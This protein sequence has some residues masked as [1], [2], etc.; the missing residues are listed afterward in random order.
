VASSLE[1]ASRNIISGSVKMVYAIVYSL[2]LGFSL[3]IGSDLYYLVDRSAR[4][5][6]VATLANMTDSYDLPGVFTDDNG[7]TIF[8]GAFTFLKPSASVMNTVRYMAKG[9]ARQVDGPWYLRQLPIW[10]LFILVPVYS[11]I[12]S[13]WKLQPFRSKQLVVMVVI[14]C[15]SYAANKGECSSVE[16][17]APF[18]YCISCQQVYIQSQRRRFCNWCV[19]NRYTGERLCPHISWNR[20]YCNGDSSKLSGAGEKMPYFNFLVFS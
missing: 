20:V 3:T 12:S 5:R 19:C 8:A 10:T 18:E 6:M 1:L 13:L 17:C 2:F 9:C 7:Q 14:S 16:A 15:C 11:I 4:P